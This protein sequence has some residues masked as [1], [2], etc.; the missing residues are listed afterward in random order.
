MPPRKKKAL[1]ARE[2]T[3]GL[4]SGQLVRAPTF[5]YG[6]SDDHLQVANSQVMEP[7][8][9]TRAPEPSCTDEEANDNIRRRTYIIP[10]N[11]QIFWDR[12]KTYMI[13]PASALGVE[14]CDGKVPAQNALLE[15]TDGHGP[16]QEQRSGLNSEGKTKEKQIQEEES[17]REPGVLQESKPKKRGRK[18]KTEMD[19]SD[20]ASLNTE[21]VKDLEVTLKSRKK[22]STLTSKENGNYEDDGTA[23]G[24]NAK[25]RGRKKKEMVVSNAVPV[26]PIDVNQAEKP[27]R[28]RKKV[29]PAVTDQ[30]ME[31]ASTN[32]KDQKK[33]RKKKEK[34]KAEDEGK[35]PVEMEGL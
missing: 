12:R 1:Q 7:S 27:K 10:P 8:S 5:L 19:S 28:G 15:E 6:E 21:L 11:E 13:S 32:P 33:G 4:L 9:P 22:K 30:A 25:K 31:N 23:E 17:I 2:Q 14:A 35:H 18:K 29:V 16:L 34:P 20:F 26:D 3:V 24:V